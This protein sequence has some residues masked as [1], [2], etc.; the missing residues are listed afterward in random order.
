MLI[1]KIQASVTNGNAPVR[2]ISH[3]HI[4]VLFVPGSGGSAK[5][6]RSV[7]SIMMNKT[8]MTSAPFRMHFYAVDFDE[9]LSFLSGSILNRQRD[10]VVRAI[11]TIQKM[12]SH[13]IVLIGH[14]LG[15][16]VLH[17]LPAHPRFTISD[18]GL[19]IVLASPISAPRRFWPI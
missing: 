17:A 1:R 8:E 19:V 14:S 4:P 10:F 16:T 9:E 6:V 5:Q 12:Y 13:K 7:A 2:A 3:D 11:S 18:M 15:G